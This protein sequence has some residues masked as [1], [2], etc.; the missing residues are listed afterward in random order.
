M[1]LVRRSVSAAVAATAVLVL[2]A[3]P[4][5]AATVDSI[6]LYYG[7]VQGI[8]YNNQAS[9]SNNSIMTA[10]ISVEK[11]TSGTIP[12][13]WSSG[14]A[15]LYRNGALCSSAAMYYYPSAVHSW[16]GGTTVKNCGRGNYTTRGSTGAYNGS[17][18]NYY[19]T[20]TS[21]IL[22]Y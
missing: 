1:N 20:A 15:S 2:A 6:L 18:Y 13:G 14:Q 21:P 17:G 5:A 7:P 4:A 12:A 3:G 9:T 22:T 19:Y 8:S 10:F 16:S 11:T